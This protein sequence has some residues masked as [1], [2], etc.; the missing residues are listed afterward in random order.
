LIT[1]PPPANLPNTLQLSP[2]TDI[3]AEFSK[4][5][6]MIYQMLGIK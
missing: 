1:T 3:A 4:I 2:A 5:T 6:A